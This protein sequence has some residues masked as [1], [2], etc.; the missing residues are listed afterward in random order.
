MSSLSL[1]N[2]E[3]NKPNS[4]FVILRF[5]ELKKEVVAVE[6]YVA[7]MDLKKHEAMGKHLAVNLVPR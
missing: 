4:L 2:L 5:V 1:H 6:A 3:D 7:M